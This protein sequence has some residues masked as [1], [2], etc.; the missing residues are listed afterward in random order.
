MYARLTG[1]DPAPQEAKGVFHVL[2]HDWCLNKNA[3]LSGVYDG[4][5]AQIVV[6]PTKY[7]PWFPLNNDIS[8]THAGTTSFSDKE[9]V[10]DELAGSYVGVIFTNTTINTDVN[11]RIQ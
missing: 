3:Y 1:I 8:F 10:L 2:E 4:A 7:G 9:S 6:G 11:V 5:T